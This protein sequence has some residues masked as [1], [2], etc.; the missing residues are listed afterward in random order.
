[1]ASLS[2]LFFCCLFMPIL[3]DIIDL[4]YQNVLD[5][6]LFLIFW[7]VC[8]S[9]KFCH[10]FIPSNRF[11]M[12]ECLRLRLVFIFDSSIFPP[13]F[14]YLF[15]LNNRYNRFDLPEYLRWN[16]TLNIL[17]VCLLV[18]LFCLFFFFKSKSAFFY[19]DNKL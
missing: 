18:Y 13:I 17:L 9:S 6:A 3:I 1:M 16:L 7:L 8:L 11:E 15:I 5:E 2:F 12:S 19:E 14:S 10:L 4:T